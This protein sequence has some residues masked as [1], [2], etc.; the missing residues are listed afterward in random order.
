[1]I[2]PMHP[3]ACRPRLEIRHCVKYFV[4]SF[5]TIQ[6]VNIIPGRHIF[7]FPVRNNISFFVNDIRSPVY[8]DIDI[9]QYIVQ[10]VIFIDTHQV[11]GGLA[12]QIRIIFIF[13]FQR[14]CHGNL[15]DAILIHR[16]ADHYIVR[17]RHILII[18]S[19]GNGFRRFF[20]PI[21]LPPLHVIC[22]QPDKFYTALPFLQNFQFCRLV[23]RL[24]H[25]NL[26]QRQICHPVRQEMQIGTDILGRYFCYHLHI[27]Q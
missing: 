4:I 10:Q 8:S 5:G 24:V 27:I 11:E 3:Q 23:R 25:Q 6:I 22:R 13:L 9:S 2:Y 15:P 17:H 18:L 12:D 19:S 14:D 7:F 20:I 26:L 16:F 21:Q 1:M